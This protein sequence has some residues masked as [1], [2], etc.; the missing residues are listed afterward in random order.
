MFRRESNGLKLTFRLAGINNQNFLM[1]DEET[2]TYWQQISGEAIAGPLKGQRLEL[3]RADELT[4][5]LWRE[6]QPGGTVLQDD[7]QFAAEYAKK[8]WETKMLKTPTV[9]SYSE[10]GRQSRDLMIGVAAFG[11]SRAY[12]YEVVL[13]E[14]LIQDR[15]GAEPIL[16]VV[17]ADGASVR[18]FRRRLAGDTP[19][20]YQTEPGVFMDS[21][22][23]LQW[24]FQGCAPTGVC[25]E[26]LNIIKDY[27]FDWRHYHP[28][29]TVF[30]GK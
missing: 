6:E 7:K 1:R 3:I 25:L 10:N 17:G 5:K 21:A 15:L 4:F 28:D 24:N 11:A 30:K 18:A 19:D 29:T 9:L 22:Q 13:K 26:P 2:G 8:D 16:L 12:P 27:W 20:F 23:G 14:K